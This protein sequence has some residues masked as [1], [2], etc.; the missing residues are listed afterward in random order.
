MGKASPKKDIIHQLRGLR[1]GARQDNRKK[2][3]RIIL[4]N[5][6]NRLV[7]SRHLPAMERIYE[8]AKEQVLK[9][10]LHWHGGGSLF[11]PRKVFRNLPG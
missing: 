2:M 9:A 11:L 10:L 3:T 6:K 4:Q 8:I 1:W 5:R 7:K